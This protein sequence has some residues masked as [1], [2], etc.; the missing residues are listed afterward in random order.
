L[1][2]GVKKSYVDAG[3]RPMSPPSH[4]DKQRGSAVLVILRVLRNTPDTKGSQSDTEREGVTTRKD[5]AI[6]GGS[7]G[8]RRLST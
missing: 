1:R 8:D 3:G 2:K 7:L 5:T 6:E 4:W